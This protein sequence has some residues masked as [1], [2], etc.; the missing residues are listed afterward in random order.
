M[1]AGQGK[2]R[3]LIADDEKNFAR[4]LKAELGREGHSTEVSANG[5]EALE[6]LK[7]QEFDVLILDLKMPRMSGEELL[8][9]IMTAYPGA[10][11]IVTTG[12]D[13]DLT[14]LQASVTLRKPFRLAEMTATIRRLLE[15]E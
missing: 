3:V 13:R 9:R 8:S 6:R 15:G 14:Q 4:V 2:I 12:L 7:E 10:K 11:V 1:R 5:R